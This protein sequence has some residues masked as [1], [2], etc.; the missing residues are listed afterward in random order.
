MKKKVL[1]STLVA[2][3]L[4]VAAVAAGLNAIFTVT[5]VNPTFT[6]CSEEGA[7]EAAALK[8]ELDRAFLG[9]STTFLD[10]DEVKAF[11][12]KNPAFR[13]ERISKGYPKTVNLTVAEREET[14]VFEHG[15]G[16]TVLDEEGKYLY[17]RTEN[18][19]RAGG[20]NIL[21][22][23]FDLTVGE[24]GEVKG[25]YFSELLEATQAFREEFGR[26]RANVVSAELTER[27]DTWLRFRM[28]E[29]VTV[30]ILHPSVKA[31]EKVRAAIA[32]YL[33]LSDE[34][35]MFG[36][37]SVSHNA[38][39]GEVTAASYNRNAGLVDPES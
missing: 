13:V 17:E 25:S 36:L 15:E 32:T 33:S 7:E 12:E 23:G 27:T 38:E 16:Y 18:V 39:T 26:I 28:A 35:R 10:L 19:N 21:L 31:A 8:E 24:N 6:T 2:L 29:G 14:F 34:E 22:K 4:L 11:V 37:I 3:V 30:E 1:I 20:K 5:L 9:R